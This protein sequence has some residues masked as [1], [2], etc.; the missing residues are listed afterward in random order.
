MFLV[1]PIRGRQRRVHARETAVHTGKVLLKAVDSSGRDASNRIKGIVLDA[2]TLF[3]HEDVDDAVLEDRV[4]S[5]AGRVSS[6]PN[7][8]VVVAGGNVTLVGPVLEDEEEAVLSAAKAVRGVRQIV[9]RMKPY[10][11]PERRAVPLGFAPRS[12]G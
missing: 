1:D 7:V 11:M 8:E 2:K 3:I 6:H 9:N 10:V 12:H 4:R 5:A